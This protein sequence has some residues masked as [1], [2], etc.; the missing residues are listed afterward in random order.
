MRKFEALPTGKYFYDYEQYKT[1]LLYTD[2][3]DIAKNYQL[4]I[5]NKIDEELLAF[6]SYAFQRSGADITNFIGSFNNIK[7]KHLKCIVKDSTYSYF[8]KEEPVLLVDYPTLHRDTIVIDPV[9]KIQ[10]GQ[11]YDPIKLRL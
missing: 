10:G 11:D 8:Y 4:I 6:L 9:W 7:F 1:S 2:V 5:Q 3:N